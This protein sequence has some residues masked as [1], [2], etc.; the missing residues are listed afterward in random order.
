MKKNDF[1]GGSS[2]L[3]SLVIVLS[4]LSSHFVSGQLVGY[5]LTSNKNAT[6]GIAAN[7]PSQGRT[8]EIS[9]GLTSSSF[10]GTN[11]QTCYGWT[12]VGNSSW[13]TSSFSTEGYINITGSFQMKANTT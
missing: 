13:Y 10:S 9:A 2:L 1:L 4:L 8:V 12:S 3:K 11:G 7:Y 6:S 5:T